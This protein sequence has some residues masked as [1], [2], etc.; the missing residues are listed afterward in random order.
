MLLPLSGSSREKKVVLGAK[1]L[2]TDKDLM[3]VRGIA[4]TAAVYRNAFAERKQGFPYFAAEKDVVH[5]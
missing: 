5:V 3:T 4:R 2:G 1:R